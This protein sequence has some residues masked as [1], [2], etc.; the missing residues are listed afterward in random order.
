MSGKKKSFEAGSQTLTVA[1]KDC[2]F[3]SE[4]SIDYIAVPA[5]VAID[6]ALKP[7]FISA[8]TDLYII[9]LYRLFCQLTKSHIHPLG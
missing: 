4:S 8:V 5:T 9:Y 3:D 7:S 6:M 1:E 2:S